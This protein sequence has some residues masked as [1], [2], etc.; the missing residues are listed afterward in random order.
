MDR[1][2]YQGLPRGAMQTLGSGIFAD[3]IIVCG[4]DQVIQDRDKSVVV[5]VNSRQVSGVSHL[6]VERGAQLKVVENRNRI[7]PVNIA[8]DQAEVPC[9]RGSVECDRG[10]LTGEPIPPLHDEI[11]RSKLRRG[12]AV[13]A[14]RTQCDVV[15]R[16]GC[17][18]A[19]DEGHLLSSRVRVG[20]DRRFR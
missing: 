1:F 9:L 11:C 5:E 18:L 14:A 16:V 8:V 10:D 2:I 17:P 3:Q 4:Q 12:E 19:D 13:C 7:V 15:R 6:G 20:Q